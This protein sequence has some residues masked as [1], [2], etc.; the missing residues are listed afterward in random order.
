MRRFTVRA[1]PGSLP[2]Q[3]TRYIRKKTV[4][5]GERCRTSSLIL[6]PSPGTRAPA[7][8]IRLNKWGRSNT[9][10][11][12]GR[13]LSSSLLF[14]T[15]ISANP[16]SPNIRGSSRPTVPDAKLSRQNLL[17]R[18][19]ISRSSRLI[20]NVSQSLSNATSTPPGARIRAISRIACSGSR[21]CWRTRSIRQASKLALRKGV[22][23]ISPLTIEHRPSN[24]A[25]LSTARARS[26]PLASRPVIPQDSGRL[27]ARVARSAPAPHPASSTLPGAESATIRILSRLT[28]WKNGILAIRSRQRQHA[29]VS[30]DVSTLRKPVAR[31]W[32]SRSVFI[33]KKGKW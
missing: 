20:E 30:P 18:A 9:C 4:P 14:S 15:W 28:S 17:M 8:S 27:E 16:H 7:S 6:V 24:P 26:V 31:D 13:S 12:T 25:V 19:A 29:S 32:R 11:A 1:V 21:I 23:R 10:S 3:E 2:G 5:R 33:H 22:F